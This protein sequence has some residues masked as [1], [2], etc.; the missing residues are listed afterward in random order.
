MSQMQ[1]LESEKMQKWLEF[2]MS[3]G[4][5]KQKKIEVVIVNIFQS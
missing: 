5:C 3:H 2:P 1:L 4:F